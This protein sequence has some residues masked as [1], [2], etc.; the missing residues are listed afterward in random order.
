MQRIGTVFMKLELSS[1]IQCHVC[2]GDLHPS[3]GFRSQI[4]GTELGP[5]QFCRGSFTSARRPRPSRSTL[6]ESTKMN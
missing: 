2:Q 1:S 5:K 6:Y 3:A 4:R